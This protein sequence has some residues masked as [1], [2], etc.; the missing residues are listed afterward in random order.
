[1]WLAVSD[2]LLFPVLV[3]DVV[4]LL[5]LLL[6]NKC[7][8]IWL[9]T[10]WY[11]VLAE[12]AFL[13][14]PH[15]LIWLAI[16]T[17]VVIWIDYT[18]IRRIWRTVNKLTNQPSRPVCFNHAWRFAAVVFVIILSY[19]LSR[20]VFSHLI[21]G[22]SHP[23]KSDYIGQA[24]FPQGDSIEITSVERTPERMV[25]KVITTSSATI[26]HRWLFISLQQTNRAFP[27]AQSRP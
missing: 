24:W 1:M 9:L 3:L 5:G 20:T 14:N 23:V 17:A 16:T 4:L 25:V 10:R 13:N 26:K 18:I 27:R 22:R 15:F 11:P 2:G 7:L 21:A 12:H 8:N 19:Q 6:A